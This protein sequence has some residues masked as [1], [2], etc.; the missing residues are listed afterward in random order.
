MRNRKSTN[1]IAASMLLA[2]LLLSACGT[3]NAAPT[4]TA[5]P[6]AAEATATSAAPAAE[7]TTAAPAAVA[8]DTAPPV[9]TADS[10]AIEATPTAA[11][12]TGGTTTAQCTLLNLNTLT[13]DQLMAAIPGFPT[14][15]VREFLEYR[16]YVSILQFRKEIGK[17][18]GADQTAQWEK[19]VYVPIDPNQAD[20]DTLMQ[21]PGVDA[22]IAAALIAGRPYA[23]NDAF[24]QA[25]SAQVSAE[26]LAQAA[27]FLATS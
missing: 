5:I 14:R 8:T 27:C 4:A 12:S 3:D 26:Q 25:L 1:F 10:A 24:L 15:M 20:A 21:I 9:A 19:Y 2:I 11:S 22:A 18:V 17:Y 6:Q 23:S 7:A 13:E 16:P